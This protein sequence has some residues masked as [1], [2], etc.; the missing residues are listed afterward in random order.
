MKKE[1]TYEALYKFN[2]ACNQ[3]WQEVIKTKWIKKVI[4]L[5]A[6]FLTIGKMK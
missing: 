4:S 5:V 2:E 3:F 1:T 6:K